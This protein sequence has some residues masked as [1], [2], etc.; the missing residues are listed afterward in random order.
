MRRSRVVLGTL[1]G[2][3]ALSSVG[4]A[5][6]LA[7]YQ[8]ANHLEV[9]TLEIALAGDNQLLVGTSP[10]IDAMKEE[11][12][13]S[14]LSDVR[15]F[16]PV[17][18]MFQSKWRDGNNLPEYYEYGGLTHVSEDGVPNSP[19]AKKGGYFSQTLY[20]Y[21]DRSV[22]VGLDPASCF[23]RAHE[24]ANAQTA[25]KLASSLSYSESEILSRLNSLEKA[26]RVSL[27][28]V[29]EG[30]FYI[31]DPHKEGTTYYAGPLDTLGS[32][33]YDTYTSAS[34]EH[35]EVLYGEVN[36]RSLV[37]YGQASPDY[38]AYNGELTSFNSGHEA[39][40][41]P[42]DEK[43]SF[44]SGLAYAEEESMEF[45]EILGSQNI[46]ENPVVFK[47]VGNVPK[48]VVVSLYIEGWDR[49]CVNANM[50]ASFLASVQFKTLREMQL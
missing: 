21:S 29:S 31:F 34:G 7:W 5:T 42:Y 19:S 2:L 50:G 38:L 10:N 28:D 9:S 23:V 46:D 45:D 48:A 37:R 36:D 41:Y 18:T 25:K 39:G 6:S 12:T 33:A 1:I 14:D 49:D 20:L 40:A 17:S 11:L 44:A 32:G 16:M 35:Y 3:V 4:V 30:E 22:Y 26:M 47:L 8:G 43:S 13:T 15:A 24:L 27:Y